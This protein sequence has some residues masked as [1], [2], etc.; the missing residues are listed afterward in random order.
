MFIIVTA[1]DM[2]LSSVQ[3][4]CESACGALTH[5]HTVYIYKQPDR[6]SRCHSAMYTVHSACQLITFPIADRP[7]DSVLIL[8]PSTGFT[9]TAKTSL[10]FVNEKSLMK[11][12]LLMKLYNI[13]ESPR[14]NS[15]FRVINDSIK[16]SLNIFFIMSHP[17]KQP[18]FGTACA[19]TTCV[20]RQWL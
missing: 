12:T 17:P 8:G 16:K 3:H 20:T 4:R 13:Y 15:Y 7:C 1:K 14:A 6:P 5:A 10:H 2:I 18:P 19:P 9:Q 11:Q